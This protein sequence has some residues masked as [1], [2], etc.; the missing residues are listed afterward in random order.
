MKT[1]HGELMVKRDH[2]ENTADP[3]LSAWRRRSY[4]GGNR[5]KILQADSPDGQCAVSFPAVHLSLGHWV[6][7]EVQLPVEA[8]VCHVGSRHVLKG[9]VADH[10]DDG[11]HHRF[12]TNTHTHTHVAS[13]GYRLYLFHAS[14]SCAH[15]LHLRLTCPF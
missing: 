10:V 5:R 1:P 12:P 8:S 9:I 7:A 15:L 4:E 13:R 6:P 11:T 2:P 3:G 14:L